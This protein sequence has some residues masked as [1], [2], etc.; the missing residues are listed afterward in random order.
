M[1]FEGD[2]WQGPRN[3]T[4]Y[5]YRK[6][7][8]EFMF[9]YVVFVDV[10][11]VLLITWQI[12]YWWSD[13]L[14][15]VVI[16]PSFKHATTIN[17]GLWFR[18]RQMLGFLGREHSVKIH[19]GWKENFTPKR[20]IQYMMYGPGNP[21]LTEH[22]AIEVARRLWRWVLQARASHNNFDSEASPGQK[23]TYSFHGPRWPLYP[24]A[25]CPS[26]SYPSPKARLHYIYLRTESKSCRRQLSIGIPHPAALLWSG[27]ILLIYGLMQL[28][29]LF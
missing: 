4:V 18:L 15:T 11:C 8:Q 26:E 23:C 1:G 3:Q 2:H 21:W 6:L 25:G 17:V 7:S 13:D 24:P 22:A 20:A 29:G 12:N 14:I 27:V 5:V 10:S 28:H 16:I 9:C 19:I